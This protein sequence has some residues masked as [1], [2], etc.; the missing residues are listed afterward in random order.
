M[1]FLLFLFVVIGISS[2]GDTPSEFFAPRETFD[3]GDYAQ[4]SWPT[5]KDYQLW[6]FPNRGGGLRV[7]C[8][9]GEI[10]TKGFIPTYR[11]DWRDSTMQWISYTMSQRSACTVPPKD[12]RY[13]TIRVWGFQED[14][15]FGMP[16]AYVRTTK[17]ECE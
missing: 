13:M 8:Y 5:S 7:V 17:I 16:L 2:C 14:G 1:R 6:C 15:G 9:D 10:D 12:A 4:Q 3:E 11:F